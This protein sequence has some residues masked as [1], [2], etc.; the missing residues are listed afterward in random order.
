MVDQFFKTAANLKKIKRKGWYEKAGIDFPESV[1]DHSYSLTCIAMVISDLLK[2][3]TQKVMKMCILHD[4]AESITGDLTPTKISRK[5]KQKLEN[6]IMR[7]ILSILPN[8]ISKK[9]FEIWNEFQQSKSQEA[10]LVHESDK[11]EMALQA[12]IY[13]KEGF[14]KEKL[15]QFFDSASKEITESTL[16][17]I[18]NDNLLK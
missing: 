8:N 11:F 12:S 6:K 13:W 7:K 14:S 4:L 9:Y 16:K 15:K 5:E 2:L 1:A 17:D 3:D 10:K 18:L